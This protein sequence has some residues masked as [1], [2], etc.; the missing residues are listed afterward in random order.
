MAR[1]EWSGDKRV[2]ANMR[3]YGDR[4]RF[5]VE[6]VATYW[7]AVIEKAAKESAPWTDRT[8][9]ARQSLR[10]Y[11]DSEAPTGYPNPRDLAAH[12]VALYLS[13]GV[14]YGIYLETRFAG[15]YAI[16]MPTLQRHYGQIARM[17]R[18]IFGR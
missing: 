12:S 16:I 8:A 2:R 5:A 6:Q 7:A 18:E 1:V 9:N 3:A 15:Q 4:V 13:H 14:E 11:V 10:A 17:L